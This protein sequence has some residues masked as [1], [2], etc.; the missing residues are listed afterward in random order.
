MTVDESPFVRQSDRE[1]T[2]RSWSI[3][4]GLNLIRIPLPPTEFSGQFDS[5]IS[6]VTA[7]PAPATSGSY[8]LMYQSITKN[9]LCYPQELLFAG[10]GCCP[11]SN[12]IIFV[13]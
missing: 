1:A 12:S 10:G 13:I 3:K 7:I 5:L 9:T 6:V 11:A 8:L 4:S 2:L